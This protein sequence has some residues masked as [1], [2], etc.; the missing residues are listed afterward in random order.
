[1]GESRGAPLNFHKV[2]NQIIKPAL[3]KSKLLSP[4]SAGN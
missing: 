2:E 1:V 4:T 3:E